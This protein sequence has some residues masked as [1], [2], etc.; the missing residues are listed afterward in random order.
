[1]I[2]RSRR[3]VARIRGEDP[4]PVRALLALVESGRAPGAEQGRAAAVCGRL[5]GAVHGGA[6]L[7]V[8]YRFQRGLALQ[9]TP[10]TGQAAIPGPARSDAMA[11]ADARIRWRST[12]SLDLESMSLST[13][14]E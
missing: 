3:M 13:A 5:R 2:R 14:S 10:P 11:G 6:P 1:A 4:G 8:L 9:G 7:G 12:R